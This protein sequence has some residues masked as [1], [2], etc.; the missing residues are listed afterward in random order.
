MPADILIRQLEYLA[1]LAREQ[2]FGR[3]AAASHASQPALSAAIRKLEQ[4]LGVTIVQRGRRFAGFTDEGRHV[5]AWAHR[6]LAE[7]DGLRNDLDRMRHGLTGTLRIGA[8]PTAVPPSPLV[9]NPF[10]ERHPQASVR[11][12]ALSSTEI[13]R[14]LEEFD[15]DVGLTYVDPEASEVTSAVTLYRERYLLLTPSGGALAGQAAVR[16]SDVAELPLCMLDTSMQNR[17]ILEHAAAAAGAR[18]APVVETDTVDTLYA[19]AASGECSSII[20]HAWL[21]AFGIPKGVT[22]IPFAEPS[23]KPAVGIVVPSQQ[24]NSITANVLLEIVSGI[25][26]AAELDRSVAAA[27]QVPAPG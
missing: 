3:A 2:H 4:E 24:S 25:D 19:H 27:A 9:T 6:I 26:I 5:V 18:L 20:A 14:K 13:L 17:R 8:I 23:P 15:I 22:A 1:A 16:W 7:R 12:E 11:I 10:R 21:H